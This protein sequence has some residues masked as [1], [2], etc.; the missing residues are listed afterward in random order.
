MSE[1]NILMILPRRT[2]LRR[3]SF[4]RDFRF[5]VFKEGMVQAF[6]EED[7]IGQAWWEDALDFEGIVRPVLVFTCQKKE[8]EFEVFEGLISHLALTFDGIPGRYPLYIKFKETNLPYIAK[9]S[10]MGF[11]PYFGEWIESSAKES[12]AK[13]QEITEALRQAYPQ[14]FG[15]KEV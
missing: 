15:Q 13:W 5:E 3:P 8:Y 7:Q 12:E 1:K 4:E 2:I 9:A 11:I 6:L 14:G 10:R